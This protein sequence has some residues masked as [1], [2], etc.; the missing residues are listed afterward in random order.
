VR[1]LLE[2][3]VKV[4]AAT[5]FFGHPDYPIPDDGTDAERLGSFAAKGCYDSYGTEGRSNI[6]NQGAVILARHGSV[7]EHSSIS[8]FVEGVTRGLTLEMNRHRHLGISQRSTRYVKEEDAAIVLEPYYASIWREYN[9]S[10]DR[11]GVNHRHLS[12]G[13]SMAAVRLLLSHLKA[14]EA[15]IVQYRREVELLIA[16][17]PEALHGFD[18]RKWARGKARNILPH[19]LETRA[20]YTANYRTWRHFI[21]LRSERHAEPE[22]RRLAGKMYDA[23]APYAPVYFEDFDIGESGGLREFKTPFSKV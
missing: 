10:Y 22:I 3:K 23:L 1:V 8:V 13:D 9:F 20:T 19:S 15:S 7:L 5:Q 2:P 16:L 11:F 12:E 14:A 4:V 21:E 6:E 18:L 17:N